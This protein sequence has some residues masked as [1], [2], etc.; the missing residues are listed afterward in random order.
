MIAHAAPSLI[1]YRHAAKPGIQLQCV[2]RRVVERK[3][4]RVFAPESINEVSHFTFWDD[5]LPLL[6]LLLVP[7]YRGQIQNRRAPMQLEVFD[8]ELASSPDANPRDP[9]NLVKR[10]PDLV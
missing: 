5:Q 2:I 4:L 7:R 10:A 3:V 6:I 8:L 9:E 1:L